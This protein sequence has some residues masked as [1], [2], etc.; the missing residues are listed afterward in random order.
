MSEYIET[1]KTVGAA[2]FLLIFIILSVIYIAK[3]GKQAFESMLKKTEEL[4]NELRKQDAEKE[5]FYKKQLEIQKNESESRVKDL[6]NELKE[7]RINSEEERKK[8]IEQLEVIN[9]NT[10]K[11]ASILEKL[12]NKFDSLNAEIMNIKENIK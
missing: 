2:G 10:A 3:Y 6:R 11:T 5:H 9:R 8:F 1:Y 7:E 4:Q 12:E